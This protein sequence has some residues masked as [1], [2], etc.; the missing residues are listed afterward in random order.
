MWVWVLVERKYGPDG[1]GW[2]GAKKEARRPSWEPALPVDVQTFS[3][4]SIKKRW[5]EPVRLRQRSLS[6]FLITNWFG[7]SS[8]RQLPTDRTRDQ[9]THMSTTQPLVHGVTLEWWIW[10]ARQVVSE[11]S[12]SGQWGIQA[13]GGWEPI[14]LTLWI[15]PV[16]LAW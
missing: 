2:E 14:V 3:P 16:L 9:E 1:V 15:L 11:W 6:A 12:V 13:V 5:P 7:C 10:K 4:R 8:S